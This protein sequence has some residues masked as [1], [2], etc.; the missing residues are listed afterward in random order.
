MAIWLRQ[1]TASQEVPLGHFVDSIDGNSEE[2]SLTIANTDIKIWKSGATSLANKNS[3]GATHMS[4]GIYSIVLDATDTNTLG[5]L[6]IFVHVAGALVVRVECLVVPAEVYDS[7]IL[8]TDKLQTDMVQIDGLATNGNNATLNLKQL[9]VVNNAGTGVIFSSTGSGGH[10]LQILGFGAGEGISV[11]GGSNGIGIEVKGGATTGSAIVATAQAGNSAGLNLVGSGAAAGLRVEG[12]ATSSAISILS[13]ATSGNGIAIVSPS[14]VGISVGSTTTHAIT[15]T[16][17]GSGNGIRIMGGSTGDSVYIASGGSSGHG[18]SITGAGNVDAVLLFGIG[19]GA[20]LNITGDLSHAVKFTGGSGG[21][22][23]QIT[24]GGNANAISITG[25]G[26]G[27]GIDVTGGATGKGIT[28]QSNTSY[29]IHINSAATHAIFTQ[30]AVGSFGFFGDIDADITGNLTGNLTG[31]V[32][33]SV[34]NVVSGVNA[35]SIDGSA[36]AAVLL[37]Y[38]ALATKT[39]LVVDH[40]SNTSSTFKTDL[41]GATNHFGDANGG[42]VLVILSEASN[43]IQAR[44]ITAFDSTTQFVTVE[45]AFNEEPTAGDRFILLGRIEV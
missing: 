21:V 42:N 27:S 34:N 7:L 4:N 10:G 22:G 15:L 38:L 41:T 18:V 1:S 32:T 29:G 14:G 37:K 2:P 39:G 43:T 23:F 12:G 28:I 35:T 17:G 9:N 3:G 31:N 26:T 6:V 36:N 5:S 30:Y 33:G 19:S 8:G 45:S 20:G 44:R 16:G 40:A 13:G 24:S 25:A 11:E